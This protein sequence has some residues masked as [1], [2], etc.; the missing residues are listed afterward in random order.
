M[1]SL[2]AKKLLIIGFAFILLV[3][4]PLTIYLLQQQ[5]EIRSKAAPSTTLAFNPATVTPNPKTGDEFNLDIMINPGTNQVSIVKL[6]IRYDQTK[7]ATSDAQT[8]CGAAICPT[9]D[10]PVTLDGPKYTNGTVGISLSIEPNVANVVQTTKKVA[11]IRFKAIAP[12][13]GGD[14]K[15]TFGP[16]TKVFSVAQADA[17]GE[18]VLLLSS[19][20]PASV[21]ISA[22]A[23]T[24]TI[25]QTQPGPSCTALRLD[26]AASGTAPYSITFTGEGTSATG[27]IS[28]A[29]FDFGDGP[30]QNVTQGGGLGTKTASVQ[31]AHTY[32][33]PS[34]YR[35][36]VVF[37]DNQNGTSNPATCTQT[38]T[39]S[40]AGTTGGGT[41]TPG[42]VTTV[43]TPTP[44]P[45]I[46][47]E[48][49]TATPVLAQPSI[50][51]SLGPG[52]TIIGLGA[53]G[54]VLSII[55]TLVFFAL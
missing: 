8:T 54:L 11:S 33:N 3:S 34:T 46:F 20:T 36:S 28:Q 27:T 1:P 4:I 45:I 42:A 22:A 47:A 41:P 2:S 31:I 12:T 50:P 10:F 26:R 29:T 43:A 15:I 48:Q 5:Q 25:A 6:D 17:E 38:I 30:V 52:D 39:V 40:Q 23:V 16:E 18:N 7:I 49:P 21:T 44:T 13:T 55:G 24:P 9:S 19:S 53:L 32:N 14:T 35:A 37:T 51:P